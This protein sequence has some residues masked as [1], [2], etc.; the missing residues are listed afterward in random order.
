MRLFQ[1]CIDARYRT[2]RLRLAIVLYLL[3]L[4]LGSIPG[5]RQE[6]G[7]L[8]P[9]FLLHFG[10]YACIAF[11]LFTGIATRP[12][13]QALVTCV[14]IAAMGALDERVQGFFPYRTAD[15][16]DWYIDVAAGIVVSGVLWRFL[17]GWRTALAPQVRG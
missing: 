9:G 1:L 15:I 12:A 5:A 14:A 2:A 10:A 13:L 3:I 6:M 7:V 17:P 4:V 16:G 11:L 8:A